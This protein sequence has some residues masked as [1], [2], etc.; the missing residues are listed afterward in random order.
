MEKERG[1]KAR[2]DDREKEPE[3]EETEKRG[4][5]E[6]THSHW[7]RLKEHKKKRSEISPQ[8]KSRTL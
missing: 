6:R 4:T 2:P 1:P 5:Y 8:E 3:R 7:K